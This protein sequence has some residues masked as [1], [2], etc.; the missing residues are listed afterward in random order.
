MQRRG[1]GVDEREL[2]VAQFSPGRHRLVRQRGV[3][4]A[5][6]VHEQ[7]AGVRARRSNQD[8][9]VE[10]RRSDGFVREGDWSIRG[11]LG[12][13]RLGIRMLIRMLI[14][15]VRSGWGR[16]EGVGI[17]WSRGTER[18]LGR[19][20]HLRAPEQH[21]L[22]RIHRAAV[23]QKH[24]RR[25]HHLAIEEPLRQRG[26][27]A[28]T[29]GRRPGERDGRGMQTRVF[30]QTRAHDSE[31]RHRSAG[32]EISR[33]ARREHRQRERFVTRVS[34]DRGVAPQLPV[35]SIVPEIVP[36]HEPGAHELVQ[37]LRPERRQVLQA[38]DR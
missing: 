24:L 4:L 22:L 35:P 5:P 37:E 27:L 25:Q 9:I 10:H 8:P 21:E 23:P 17:P 2:F 31:V 20:G 26:E 19:R 13:R 1:D 6:D 32:G 38:L 7:L 18:H 33:Q 3:E 12:P 36:P 11:R 15:G 16:V 28:A 29:F 34:V 30:L 14:L